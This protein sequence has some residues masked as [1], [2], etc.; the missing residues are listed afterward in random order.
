[1]TWTELLT[2]TVSVILLPSL[3][4]LARAF[5]PVLLEHLQASVHNKDMAAFV[6][7][8][9][10]AGGRILLDM[11]TAKEADPSA[12]MKDVIETGV[13][14]EVAALST[15]LISDLVLKLGAGPDEVQKMVEGELGK[16]IVAAGVMPKD[17]VQNITQVMADPRA[18][19]T[20]AFNLVVPPGAQP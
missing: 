13:K 3:G 6:G 11:L 8:G 2:W 4:L 1:M 15:T 18:A 17:T 12:S 9:S 14:R 5:L 20:E 7:A 10:R 16:A 19:L